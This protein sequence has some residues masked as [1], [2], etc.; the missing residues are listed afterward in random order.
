MNVFKR[1]VFVLAVLGC[2]LAIGVVHAQTLKKQIK[3]VYSANLSLGGF[4]TG[5]VSITHTERF[6]QGDSGTY[7]TDTYDY[8]AS[9]TVGG[10]EKVTLVFDLS[11]AQQQTV[12][13]APGAEEECDQN[14][15]G[16]LFITGTLGSTPLGFKR[17][18]QGGNGS[19]I[20]P[21]S[22]EFNDGQLGVSGSFIK[23]VCATRTW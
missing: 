17:A 20:G 12:V 3:C 23:G 19:T 18:L 13:C 8:R 7:I 6:W 9:S 15:R 5:T 10:V 21:L 4:G 11:G 14:D 2:S 22:A 1:G 16:T